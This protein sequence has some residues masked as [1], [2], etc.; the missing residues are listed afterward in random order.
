MQGILKKAVS[1]ALDAAQKELAVAA[2]SAI[3]NAAAR[4]IKGRCLSCDR[5]VQ[6][7]RPEPLGPLPSKAG[8]CTLL[9]VIGAMHHAVSVFSTAAAQ[10]VA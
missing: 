2:A 3:N 10:A 6:P 9:T 1:G 4:A 5:E 7:R 8:M